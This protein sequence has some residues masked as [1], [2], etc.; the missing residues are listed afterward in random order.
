MAT[1]NFLLQKL[2]PS[3]SRKFN[4]V[5]HLILLTIEFNL[6]NCLPGSFSACAPTTSFSYTK[7][8]TLRR[9]KK[10]FFE[11]FFKFV[12][13]F[14]QNVLSQIEFFRFNQSNRL[15]KLSCK[16][17]CAQLFLRKS[18]GPRKS[19][20]LFFILFFTNIADY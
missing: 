10:V 7:F 20:N 6:K 1:P 13:V 2:W 17:D 3:Q 14:S 8:M 12:F 4:F 19:Q 15:R 9:V 18:Y 5:D 16:I 11:D